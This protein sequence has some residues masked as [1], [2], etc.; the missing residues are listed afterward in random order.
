MVLYKSKE[1]NKKMKTYAR[2]RPKYARNLNAP[3]GK[4]MVSTGF[5]NYMLLIEWKN[6]GLIQEL[7]NDYEKFVEIKKELKAKG[8]I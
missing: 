7:T 4:V 2:I 3:K 5:E 8:L 6:K 1:G